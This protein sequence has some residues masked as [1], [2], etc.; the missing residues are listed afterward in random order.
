MVTVSQYK[1]CIVT[2]WFWSAVL[3]RGM[4]ITI[5]DCIATWVCSG[6]ELYCNR[7][8]LVAGNFVSQYTVV[9]CD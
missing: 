9:Y 5:E 2:W 7:K 3:A 6:F 4:C 1:H 8:G